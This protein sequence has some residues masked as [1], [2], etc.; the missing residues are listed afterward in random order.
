[1]THSTSRTTLAHSDG[2]APTRSTARDVGR[3]N[4]LADGRQHPFYRRLNQ[5]LPE[6]GFDDFVEPQ[7]ADFY[8]KTMG[9]PPGVDFRLL[10]IGHFEG[11]DAERGVASPAADSLPLR[12]LRRPMADHDIATFWA[13]AW[14]RPRRTT[15]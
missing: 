1:M 5:L 7:C 11:I 10:L 9:W 14:T 4:G 8:A 13:S 15:R 3:D 12:D 2:Q 6:H